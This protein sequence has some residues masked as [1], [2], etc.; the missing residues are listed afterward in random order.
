[1]D[2]LEVPGPGTSVGL[3]SCPGSEGVL[4][5]KLPASL[6]VALVHDDHKDLV[7]KD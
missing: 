2:L 7:H 3:N 4:L 5:V 6:F 1:M